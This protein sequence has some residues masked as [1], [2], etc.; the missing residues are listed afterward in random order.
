M[1]RTIT[2]AHGS[3][4]RLTGELVEQVFISAFDDEQGRRLEDSAILPRPGT[5]I[6]LTTDAF[7]VKPRFFPGGD[8]GKLSICGTVND[9]AVAGA[10]PVALT[11]AFVIEEGVEIDE[12]RRIAASMSAT[13]REAGVR[14]VAG[15]T[16]VVERGSGDGVYIATAGYGLVPDGRALDCRRI[17][18]G[19]RILVSGDLGRHEAAV[20]LARGE[21]HFEAAIES[22]CAPL[23]ETCRAV[24]AA[25][26]S[27]VRTIRDATR[28]GLA[29]VLCEWARTAGAGL[30]LAESAIP[31]DPAVGAVCEMLG[32]DPLYLACEGRLVTVVSP[33]ATEA[34]AG[35]LQDICVES[36]VIGEVTAA[37]D[38]R[39]LL[40]TGVGG[41]RVL[42]LLTGGQLPRIC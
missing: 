9:L 29:T 13:A 32:L 27:G 17:E 42:D 36:A 18:P 6:A 16:K 39:V 14:L 1:D 20:L 24:L 5:R 33:D 19:D 25:G 3:G 28:G 21:L 35:A 11:A 23:A 38:G 31:I 40:E 37:A 26:G 30:L 8:I 22:D 7:V 41:R 2:L 4:G 10:E 12:L 15:D 34:V